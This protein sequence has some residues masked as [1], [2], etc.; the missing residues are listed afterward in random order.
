MN[1][2]PEDSSSEHWQSVYCTKSADSVSWF[3]PHLDMSLALIEQAGLDCHSRVVDVGGGA[4]T[5][6]DD[7][8]ARGV[9]EVT[10][11]D[12]SEQA[13]SVSRARLEG[14]ASGVRWLTGDVLLQPFQQGS[15]DLWHDRAVLHFLVDLQ[16]AQRYAKQA[17]HALRPG[18]HAV[19]GGFAPDGPERCS[20]LAVARRSARDIVELFGD[21]F[22]LIEQRIEQHRTPNGSEQS[23]LWS[24]LRRL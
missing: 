21:G 12:L 2:L 19:I 22:E 10:V 13:L 4:S 15:F 20:G 24:L 9:L 16:D 7:L 6:V 17:R 18:G 1:E 8:L 5:L 11:L 14:R 23:F 3:Q